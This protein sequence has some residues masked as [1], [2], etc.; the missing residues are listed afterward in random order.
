MLAARQLL[1]MR[2]ARDRAIGIA[3]APVGTAFFLPDP[4]VRRRV[5]RCVGHVGLAG[6]ARC[7]MDRVASAGCP[8]MVRPGWWDN[9]PGC[10]GW[11]RNRHFRA[12]GATSAWRHERPLG[13][14]PQL[15]PRL[16]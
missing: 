10:R 14:H 15:P 6:L 16:M 1:L 7:R 8:I 2:R 4:D 13:G 11:V 9:P 12:F 5:F 3:I